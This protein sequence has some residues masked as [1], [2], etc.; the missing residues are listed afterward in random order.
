[1]SVW[2]AGHKVGH[3]GREDAQRLRPGLLRLQRLHRRP[4]ALPGV[5]VGGGSA[6]NLGVFLN[7]DAAEFGVP[8][9]R[10]RPPRT[11]NLRTGLSNAVETDP[12]DDRYD[13]GWLHTLPDD[14]AQRLW[15][16]HELLRTETDMISRH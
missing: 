3:L 8:A 15:R 7:F 10:T 1:M 2:V 5:I 4:I 12:A 16:L 11:G 14:P 13:L 9:T 6:P